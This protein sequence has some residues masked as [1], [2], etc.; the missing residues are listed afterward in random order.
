MLD[1]GADLG[2]IVPLSDGTVVCCRR[3]TDTN[4][5]GRVTWTDANEI[6][7]VDPESGSVTSL[8]KALG[9]DRKPLPRAQILLHGEYNDPKPRIIYSVESRP[10]LGEFE[11]LN[12]DP[13]ADPLTRRTFIGR[14]SIVE[15]FD[16]ERRLL[17]ARKYRDI[18]QD[19]S[20]DPNVDPFE[21]VQLLFGGE[22]AA[23][24]E[25]HRLKI[26]ERPGATGGVGDRNLRNEAE[27][28][29][30]T[31]EHFLLIDH[32]VVKDRVS[33]VTRQENPQWIDI[34]DAEVGRLTYLGRRRADDEIRND[35]RIF[36]RTGSIR[37][38]CFDIDFAGNK[39]FLGRLKPA[40]WSFSYS[41]Q[42]DQ[43]VWCNITEPGAD[44]QWIF[45]EDAASIRVASLAKGQ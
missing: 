8:Y 39:R 5:D 40:D 24:G 42:R 3:V 43:I 2:R 16:A 23:D 38:S 36:V 41:R 25:D 15:A 35:R 18:N 33:L 14:G 27:I 12:L 17:I 7:R 13:D 4:G 22:S 44:K 31:A 21:H 1:V 20:V 9:E 6:V 34:V 10:Y 28:I 30:M 19:G 45:W 29:D 26:G 11:V 32:D 37:A